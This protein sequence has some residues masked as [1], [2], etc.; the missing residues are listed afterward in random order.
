MLS[1]GQEFIKVL[2]IL[3]HQNTGSVPALDGRDKVAPQGRPG[4]CKFHE[5]RTPVQNATFS[6]RPVRDTGEVPGAPTLA[7]ELTCQCS[8]RGM[9]PAGPPVSA[10]GLGPQLPSTATPTV[11]P[12]PSSQCAPCQGQARCLRGA[13]LPPPTAPSSSLPAVTLPSATTT[14]PS[15]REPGQ[16]LTCPGP[17]LRWPTS[18]PHCSSLPLSPGHQRRHPR[19]LTSLPPLGSRVTFPGRLC[20][21]APDPS[22]G[23]QLP[24]L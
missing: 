12:E 23:A 2:L 22:Q 20:L 17:Q 16:E 13:L 8:G 7:L 21:P 10:A 9:H 15:Q 24:F 6:A 19:N 18:S 4:V 11:K 14:V 1:L 5:L 3:C